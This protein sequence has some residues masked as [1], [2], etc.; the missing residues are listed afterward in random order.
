MAA[1]KVMRPDYAANEEARSRFLREAQ[2]AAALK[3]DNIVTIYQVGEAQ[4]MPFL[5]M[6]LLAGKS[7]DD[8]LRPDRRATVAETL[9]IGK[10][11]A[12]ALAAAHATGLIHR[13][14]KPANLW[15]EAPRGRLKILDFGLARLA[16]SNYTQLTE[17][18]SVL[19]TPAFMAPEQARGDTVDHRCDLFSVGCVL[20]RMLAG[21]LPFQ[22]TT[23]YAVLT[24]I[25]SE[26]PRPAISV[27]PEIPQRLSDLVDRL[28]A[29]NPAERVQSAQELFD[30]LTSIEKGIK[31]ILP[32]PARTEAGLWHP[33]R[34]WLAWSVGLTAAA[35][36]ILWIVFAAM[37]RKSEKVELKPQPVVSSETDSSS[38]KVVSATADSTPAHLEPL[39]ELNTLGEEFGASLSPTGNVLF[40]TRVSANQSENGTFRAAR[41]TLDAPFSKVDHVVRLRQSVT[42]RWG[43]VG[44]GRSRETG[45][46]LYSARRDGRGFAEAKVIEELKDQTNPR[47]PW[48][49]HDG[50]TLVFQRNDAT[51]DYPGKVSRDSNDRSEFVVTTRPFPGGAWSQPVRLPLNDDPLYVEVLNWPALTDDLLTVF[52][53]I[54]DGKSA[55]VVYATRSNLNEPFANPR[56]VVVAGKPL[57]G[58]T[59]RYDP[60]T[61]ELFVARDLTTPG[62][63]E[64]WDLW[65]V[66]NFSLGR[67]DS[68]R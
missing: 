33:S 64:N 26:T 2:A 18:G 9:L 40:F 59:P 3:H 41:R 24:A 5:A 37:T 48:I 46:T 42:S 21:Q 67:S 10:Q 22:G 63:P 58:R 16:A 49:S 32:L 23:T 19:G 20:Y 56:S 39:R 38:S 25:A 55:K 54:G 15:L 12:R 34:R 45:T 1:L 52:F 60:V 53:C 8:W 28:L 44:I 13:D 61:R 17:D 27:R 47:S 6:E 66:K 43:L 62:R 11:T 31:Q 30:E 50:L 7:L 57:L 29:K 65:V 51:G 14:I 36:L 68:A 4:G 35:A